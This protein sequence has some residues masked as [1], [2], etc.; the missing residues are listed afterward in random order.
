MATQ[1]TDVEGSSSQHFPNWDA[2]FAYYKDHYCRGCVHVLL[3]TS[4]QN[5]ANL[6]LMTPDI[7]TTNP[8][9]KKSK[10]VKSPMAASA[11]SKRR[12]RDHHQS[13]S[14]SAG[15]YL[16]LYEDDDPVYPAPAVTFSTANTNTPKR[17]NQLQGPGFGGLSPITP[18]PVSAP[19]T[20]TIKPLTYMCDCSNEAF[21]S[22]SQPIEILTDS[23]A[24][25]DIRPPPKRRLC[26]CLRLPS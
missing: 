26:K 8:R 22:T 16:P 4:A 23:E 1:C 9:K 24:E 5:P 19:P 14:S 20:Y 3:R 21:S 12:R 10:T 11:A 25:I 13:S 18:T 17:R 6:C 15:N 2:A 7:V